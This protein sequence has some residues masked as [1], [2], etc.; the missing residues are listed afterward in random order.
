MSVK[1]DNM[2]QQ[3]IPPIE[4]I[5]WR[6]LNEATAAL[7]RLN[8]Y[9]NL[10]STKHEIYPSEFLGQCSMALYND[11]MYSIIKVLEKDGAQQALTFWYIKKECLQEMM[12]YLEDVETDLGFISKMTDKLMLVRHKT[13]FHL[14]RRGIIDSRAVWLEADINFNDFQKLVKAV[15]HALEKL[16]FEKVSKDRPFVSYD[17][18]DARVAVIELNKSED[19]LRHRFG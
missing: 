17:G 12:S 6:N 3:S 13:L 16:Y 9:N 5:I 8:A 2:E 14:D 11:M 7:Q 19:Y 4:K 15:H 10:W 18:E 1:R